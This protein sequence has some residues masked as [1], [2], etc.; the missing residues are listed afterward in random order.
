MSLPEMLVV[1]SDFAINIWPFAIGILFIVLLI[2]WRRKYSASYLIC[3]LAF[4]IYLL[5]ALD[6]VFFPL[7]ISGGYADAM[8]AQPF[9]NSINLIPF[10]FGPFGTLRSAFSTLL[11]NVVLTIPFGFGVSFVAR[12]RAR[13]V[14]WLAPGLGFGIEIA[15]LVISLLLGYAY[16]VIDINDVLMNMLGVLIGYGIFSIFAWLYLAM[17]QR[18]AIKGGGLAGYVYEVASR[19]WTNDYN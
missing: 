13:D 18:L 15:Q 11:L 1:F 6:K 4:S 12:V 19:T 5:F 2:L 17:M 3:F 9:I 10:Y 14:L 8:R 16:R 7:H